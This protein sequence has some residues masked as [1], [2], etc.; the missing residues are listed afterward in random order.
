MKKAVWKVAACML[1]AWGVTAKVAEAANAPASTNLYVYGDIGANVAK[2]G[3]TP[4][5]GGFPEAGGAAM[6]VSEASTMEGASTLQLGVGYRISPAFAVELGYALLGT[7]KNTFDGRW[8]MRP[9]G[10]PASF[11]SNQ[12]VAMHGVRLVALGIYPLSD[13]FELF[14]TVGVYGLNYKNDPT[15]DMEAMGIRKSSTFKVRPAI[16]AGITYRI[17]PSLH[18]RGQ[19]EFINSSLSRKVDNIV[20]GNTQ[21]IR[22]GL[23]YAF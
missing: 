22:V 21:S 14:G 7:F 18:V 23:V 1:G 6:S 8:Q 19:Y 17:T 10:D 9:G 3:D 2:A 15:A 11:K 12:N 13:K 4:L 20:I 16:G 5:R